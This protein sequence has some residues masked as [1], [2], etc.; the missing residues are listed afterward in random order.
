[1]AGLVVVGLVAAAVVTGGAAVVG[2]VLGAAVVGGVAGTG[3][4]VLAAES[5]MYRRIVCM[6]STFGRC[7]L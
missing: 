6:D 7:A 1:M 3:T 2:V 4:A 5:A